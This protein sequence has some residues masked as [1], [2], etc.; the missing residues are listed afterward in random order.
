MPT[1]IEFNDAHRKNIK[2]TSDTVY[3][4]KDDGTIL[5]IPYE[6]ITYQ[7]ADSRQ[8]SGKEDITDIQHIEI[9]EDMVFLYRKN[10]MKLCIPYNTITSHK[11]GDEFYDTYI[12]A[13]R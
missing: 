4:L 5:R 13:F 12:K 3:L 7:P 8:K 9:T 6:V 1:H 11:P 2:I 10:G